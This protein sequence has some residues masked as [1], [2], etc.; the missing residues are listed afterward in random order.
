VIDGGR[1][2][3]Y[4]TPFEVYARPANRLVADF[5]GL[6]NLVPGEVRELAG[7]GGRVVAAGLALD[8]AALGGLKPGQAVDVA[9]RPENIRLT[10]LASEASG[11]RGDPKVRAP[12]GAAA[13]RAKVTNHVFLGNISEYYATL[14]GG[15]VLRVQTHPLERFAVGDEVALEV[16]A[17]QCSVFRRE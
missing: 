8:I 17:A 5:M 3:Q 9:I 13:P 2:Q 16:D 11:R 1:L 15:Q 10:A 7:A 12:A 14:A 4:G 6:V